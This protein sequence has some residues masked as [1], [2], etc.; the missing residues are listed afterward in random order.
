MKEF[1]GGGGEAGGWGLGEAEAG[2][3]AVLP[4]LGLVIAAGSAAG[5]QRP[6]R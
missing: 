5:C 6:S 3:V 4:A 2:S 1:V